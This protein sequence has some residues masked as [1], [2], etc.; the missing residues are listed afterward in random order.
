MNRVDV[1]RLLKLI[2]ALS[3]GFTADPGTGDAW[4]ELL[5]DIPAADAELAVKAHYATGGPW[6]DVNDIRRRVVAAR[7]LLPPEA[8]AAYAQARR[9]NTWLDRRI[10]PEPEIH[11]AAMAAAREVGWSTFDGLEGYAHKRFVDAYRPTATAA[12]EK[13]LTTPLPELEAQMRAPKALPA[14]SGAAPLM[15]PATAVADVDPARVADLHRQLARAAVA[16][17]PPAPR[18]DYDPPTEADKIRA[19]DALRQW[20][21]RATGR[22]A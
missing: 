22:S 7:G 13:A 4:A 2:G 8:E 5:A 16:K 6:I 15:L 12:A 9:M 19:L 18:P 1:A 3:S 10:G 14:G 20:M 17:A 11:P 21:N